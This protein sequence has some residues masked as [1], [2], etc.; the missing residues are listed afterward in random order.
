MR[1]EKTVQVQMI[2]N[3]DTS[4]MTLQPSPALS[5]SLSCPL[6]ISVLLSV[7]LFYDSWFSY[8]IVTC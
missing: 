7:Y 1:L 2:A 6:L 4:L 8:S 5:P 3:H